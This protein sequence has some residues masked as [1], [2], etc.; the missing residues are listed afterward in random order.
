MDAV[1]FLKERARQ[2]GVSG[3][4]LIS[5]KAKDAEVLV[6]ETEKWSKEHPRKTKGA[7]LRGMFPNI[8]CIDNGA[9]CICPKHLGLMGECP[10]CDCDTCR[11]KFWNQEVENDEEI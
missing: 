10:I 8:E 2:L 5:M 4:C 7:L 3:D 11:D 1:K 9:P 6:A